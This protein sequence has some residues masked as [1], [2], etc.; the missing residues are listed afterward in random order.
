[1]AKKAPSPKA[2][3]K[4][5]VFANIAT[6]TNLSK[7]EVGAVFDALTAEIGK[8][9]GKKGTGVFQI[10]GLCKIIVDQASRPSPPRRAF[11]IPFKP[12]ELMDVRRQAGQERRQGSPAE[13][14]EGHGLSR[15]AVLSLRT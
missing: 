3:S 14:P 2:A 13:E 4:S 8:A 6:A 5:E 10:P 11:R 12:G 7:K 15:V 1:M 9:L